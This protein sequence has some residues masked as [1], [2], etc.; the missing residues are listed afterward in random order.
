MPS[1]AT[2]PSINAPR[3]DLRARV[4]PADSAA[5]SLAPAAPAD[6]AVFVRAVE[7]GSFSAVARERDCAASQVS[8]GC[9]AAPPMA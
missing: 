7:L 9:C 3:P 6:L 1:K 2:V 4:E 8:C 5:A